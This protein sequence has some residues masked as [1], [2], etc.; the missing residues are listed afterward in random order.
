M[1]FEG[2]PQPTSEEELKAAEK[3]MH[4]SGRAM[5]VDETPEEYKAEREASWAE[6]Q[7]P[8]IENPENQEAE[9][10]IKNSLDTVSDSGVVKIYDKSGKFVFSGNPDQLMIFWKNKDYGTIEDIGGISDEDGKSIFRFGAG[11]GHGF[12]DRKRIEGIFQ[13]LEGQ[14]T[15]KKSAAEDQQKIVEI[16]QTLGQETP[17][18]QPQEKTQEQI[19]TT[20]EAKAENPIKQEGLF[21]DEKAKQIL[22]VTKDWAKFGGNFYDHLTGKN[23]KLERGVDYKVNPDG[24]PDMASFREARQKKIDAWLQDPSNQEWI[25]AGTQFEQDHKQ[26]LGYWQETVKVKQSDGTFVDKER[27]TTP[28]F[29]ENGWLYYESNY[30]DKQTGELKQPERESTKYR[31]YFNCE[32][33]DILPTYQGVIEELSKDPELQKLGFQIKTADVSKVSPQEIGQI[34]NQKDRIVLYL[35]EQ[36]MEKALPILQKYAEQNRQKFNKEGVLLA[37]PLVDSQGQEISGV[38]ITSETKGMS[39]DPTESNKKYASFSDMQ[40]KVIESCFRSITAGLKNPK[41][42]E[43]MATKYPV[44][45]EALSKLPASASVEDYMKGILSDPNGEEFLTKNLKAIYPQWSKAFG[46]SERNIAFKES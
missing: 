4:M 39:P 16:R 41:T 29:Y 19:A 46:M 17:V 27:Y 5:R 3:E 12:T 36:G 26:E 28:Y 37:Q 10:Q 24:T 43:T 2:Q 21:D 35:G 34:M 1:K 7:Q 22:E 25:A 9:Q 45:K 13:Q 30:F 14:V 44:M 8:K 23:M 42:L 40:S 31:V 20:P 32:G 15:R 11:D 33:G 18:P 6:K 38:R